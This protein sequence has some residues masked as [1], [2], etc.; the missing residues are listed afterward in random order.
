[1]P[2]SDAAWLRTRF[3]LDLPLDTWAPIGLRLE[4]LADI[5]HVYLNGVLVGRDWSGCPEQL[6]Y[7]PEGLLDLHG[8]NTLALALWRRG[9]TFATARVM[10]ET[11]AVEG[12]HVLSIENLAKVP[13]PSQGFDATL[14]LGVGGVSGGPDRVLMSLL[15]TSIPCRTCAMILFSS[16][17]MVS[18]LS[19][20]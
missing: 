11:Y 15:K 19:K 14:H 3:A 2:T 16:P 1:M 12:V 20:A 5:A 6:F 8:E 9:Q 17:S 13:K 18:N 7:L 10:L 4:H